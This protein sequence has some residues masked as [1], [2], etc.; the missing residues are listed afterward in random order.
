MNAIE[1][2]KAACIE[3]SEAAARI[4]ARVKGRLLKRAQT[5]GMT[6]AE[7]FDFTEAWMRQMTL[8]ARPSMALSGPMAI[9]PCPPSGVPAARRPD[10][11][12]SKGKDDVVTQ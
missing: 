6:D 10:A 4:E 5:C 3:A 2:L 7:A 12:K 8:L 1:A 11:N 9:K